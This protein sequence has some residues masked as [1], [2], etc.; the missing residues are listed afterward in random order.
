MLIKTYVYCMYKYVRSVELLWANSACSLRKVCFAAYAS[1]VVFAR[2]NIMLFHF[3]PS[4][5]ALSKFSSR[6]DIISSIIYYL[7]RW[8]WWVHNF[9]FFPKSIAFALLCV[10]EN[11]LTGRRK[12]SY[13]IE[14]IGS[15]TCSII[16]I[17]DRNCIPFTRF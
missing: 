7:I 8:K 6:L 14:I 5:V 11:R 9:H 1:A 13:E 4:I 15:S 3:H 2:T 17:N 16:I 10:C 12:C